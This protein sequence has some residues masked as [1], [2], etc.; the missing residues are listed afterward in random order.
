MG[1]FSALIPTLPSSVESSQT[2]AERLV[3]TPAI[4]LSEDI[5]WVTLSSILIGTLVTLVLGVVGSCV[6]IQFR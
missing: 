1:V 2:D 4:I 3:T 5:D 6:Y